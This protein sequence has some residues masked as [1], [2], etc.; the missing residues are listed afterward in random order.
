MD[1]DRGAI[2]LLGSRIR[3]THGERPVDLAGLRAWEEDCT[4]NYKWVGCIGSYA[5]APQATADGGLIEPEYGGR[6]KRDVTVELADDEMVVEFDYDMPRSDTVTLP[7]VAQ[8]VN[9]YTLVEKRGVSRHGSASSKNHNDLVHVF[10]RN[11]DE[12][13]YINPHAAMA[14]VH[15]RDS[16]YRP[17]QLDGLEIKTEFKRKGGRGHESG[18]HKRLKVTR[19]LVEDHD[20]VYLIEFREEKGGSRNGSYHRIKHE[21]ATRLVADE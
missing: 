6:D 17:T 5:M 1:D 13:T 7:I 16:D 9:Q 14:G 11:G 12:W 10:V 19:D 8:T 21:Q 4:E 15:R 3:D 18:Y 2:V 20:E